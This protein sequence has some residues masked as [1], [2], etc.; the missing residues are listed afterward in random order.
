MGM[1]EVFKRFE[2]QEILSSQRIDPFAQTH[3]APADRI[4]A[5]QGLST[6]H[7]IATSRT[8]PNRNTPST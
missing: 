1:V 6:H 4:A 5:M 3:P 7:P 2:N 8:A